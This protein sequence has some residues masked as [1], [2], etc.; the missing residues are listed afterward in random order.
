MTQWASGSGC[1]LVSRRQHVRAGPSG[2]RQETRRA[3]ETGPDRDRDNGRA[4]ARPCERRSESP[5]NRIRIMSQVDQTRT[6]REAGTKSR[7][8]WYH[9]T[10]DRACGRRTRTP[11]Q[12][13][14]TI[15]GEYGRSTGRAGRGSLASSEA[16]QPGQLGLR[17][18]L[19]PPLSGR[20]AVRI[21]RRPSG[22]LLLGPTA[23]CHS[24]SH[25][26]LDQC[27]RRYRRYRRGRWTAL[28][29]P[30]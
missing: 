14:P 13:S 9:D 8:Y 16:R 25:D 3:A 1:K 20:L 17:M 22:L 27:G 19:C 2:S 11:S 29:V 10:A 23:S 12:S 30:P 4:W 24:N 6:R 5:D 21:G 15:Q 26:H 18:A 7:A 28:T